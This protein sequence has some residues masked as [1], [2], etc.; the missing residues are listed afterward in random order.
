MKIILRHVSRYVVRAWVKSLLV[1]LVALFFML[2]LGWLQETIYQAETEVDRLYNTTLVRGTVRP[3]ATNDST[4]V[5]MINNTIRRETV[6]RV[7]ESGLVQDI[8]IEAGYDWAVIIPACVPAGG[9][10][11]YCGNHGAHGGLPANWYEI[12]EL[13]LELETRMFTA[14]VNP[15]LGINCVDSFTRANSVRYFDDI[16]GVFRTFSDGEPVQNF[17]IN[18]AHGFDA[19][20]IDDFVGID[21]FANI[22]RADGIAGMEG[23][24]AS[25]PIPIIIS[26]ELANIRGLEL[27]DMAYIGV[28]LGITQVWNHYPAV[29]A[30]IHNRNIVGF[31]LRDSVIVPLN[32]LEYMAS[33]V[34]GYRT[35][36]FYVDPALN[37]EITAV[38][39]E[40]TGL[41]RQENASWGHTLPSLTLNDGE[42]LNM[43]GTVDQTLG[44]LALLYP[45]A[46]VLSVLIA[47][48]VSLLLMLQN[49]KN[50]AIMRVLGCTQTKCRITLCVETMFICFVGLLIGL[51]VLIA[52]GWGF[53]LWSGIVLALLYFIGTCVGAVIGAILITRRPPLE[54]LQVKE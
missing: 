38:R 34:I 17:Y 26:S 28:T 52:V 36:E 45:V 11:C 44:L 3:S 7:V 41:L 12:A 24:D 54:L 32:A 27:G 53:G 51:G 33:I 23:F 25:T 1:V 49:A 40:L 47:G 30:G 31:R 37:R 35:I 29:V 42:L 22:G 16:P 6:E 14:L 5:H 18:F 39:E 48:G 8:Y 50:A 19:N 2:A 20:A 21:D 10:I 4:L 43:V 13:D 46:V 9:D 15:M